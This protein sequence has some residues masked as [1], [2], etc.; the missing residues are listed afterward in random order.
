M[1]KSNV[2]TMSCVGVAVVPDPITSPEPRYIYDWQRPT[3]TYKESL[4]ARQVGFFRTSTHKRVKTTSK[5]AH[6]SWMCFLVCRLC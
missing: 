4:L 2:D 1:R 3:D 6:P 5:Y